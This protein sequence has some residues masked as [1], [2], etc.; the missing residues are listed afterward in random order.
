MYLHVMVLKEISD[1]PLDGHTE[2]MVKKVEK[3]YDLAEIKGRDV[4]AKGTSVTQKFPRRQE[5]PNHKI[6]DVLL[7][8]RRHLPRRTG[9]GI[10][11]PSVLRAHIFFT[12]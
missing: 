12:Y 8:H 5:S 9:D 7:H 3:D 10:P 1:K 11:S 2:S 6:L 4:L